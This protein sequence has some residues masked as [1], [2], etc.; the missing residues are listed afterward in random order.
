V[1]ARTV[2]SPDAV[3]PADACPEA[4]FV[5][6]ASGLSADYLNRIA[7]FLMLVELLPDCPDITADLSAWTPVSY[8]EHYLA[9]ALPQAG[10]AIASY[11]AMQ[12]RRRRSFESAVEA[13]HG[14][15]AA[16]LAA[17]EQARDPGELADIAARAS[18]AMHTLI[19]ET[20]DLI[21][22]GR[23]PGIASARRQARAAARR[24]ARR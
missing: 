15:A 19:D 3:P 9:S 14:L 4:R 13:M 2:F 22:E 12:A 20:T 7:G 11:E 24:L 8:R 21:N 6:P 5:H 23:A 18:K 1:K 16:T 17:L 10:E